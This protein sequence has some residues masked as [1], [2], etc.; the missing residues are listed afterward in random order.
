VA[1]VSSEL[2]ADTWRAGIVERHVLCA[3]SLMTRAM[4]TQ[5]QASHWICCSVQQ[6]SVVVFIKLWKQ[7]LIENFI[8][9]CKKKLLLKLHTLTS[10]FGQAGIIFR[11]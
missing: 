7:K 10:M 11:W 5:P 8:T 6:Q 4:C 1:I 2:F 3:Q 9:V